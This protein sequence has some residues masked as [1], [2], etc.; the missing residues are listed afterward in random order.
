MTPEERLSEWVEAAGRGTQTKLAKHLGIS[1]VY[2][3]RWMNDPAYKIQ[4][5][6]MVEI[7]DFFG[8]QRGSLLDDAI[9]SV[10]KVPIR[11]ETSCGSATSNS[12]QE[13]G[14]TCNYNGEF[15]HTDLYCVIACGES[16]S[17]EIEDGDEIICDPRVTAVHGDLVHYTIHGESAVKLYTID[18]DAHLLQFVP[19]NLSPDFKVRTIRLDDEEV[20]DLTVV[21]VVSVNKLKFNNRAARLKLIGR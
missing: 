10:S 13:R 5:E 21:K 9:K 2:V 20:S 3:N 6:Y 12:N 17:P 8:K 7:E 15:F 11:G 18:E 19:Y 14:K 4:T 16:M 1:N